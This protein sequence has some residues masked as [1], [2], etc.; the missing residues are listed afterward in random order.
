MAHVSKTHQHR[1]WRITAS[2]NRASLGYIAVLRTHALTTVTVMASASLQI[3]TRKRT[4]ENAIATLGGRA[5]TARHLTERHQPR[6]QPPRHLSMHLPRRQPP[7]HLST[8]LPRH[9]R[10]HLPRHQPPKHPPLL[11]VVQA[12]PTATVVEYATTPPASVS[13]TWVDTQPLAP[14]VASLRARTQL[15]RS[16]MSMP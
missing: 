9:Q 2:A 4:P 5:T 10:R 7:R 16:M 11:A 6:R 1:Q 3:Q 15:S 14:I 8:H 13:A 12:V